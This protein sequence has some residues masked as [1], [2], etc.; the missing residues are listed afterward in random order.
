MPPPGAG[1]AIPF[2]RSVSPTAD[3]AVS[4]TGFSRSFGAPAFAT[5]RSPLT[6]DGSVAAAR[7]ASLPA[8][9]IEPSALSTSRPDAFAFWIAPR[10]SPACAAYSRSLIPCMAG[11]QK[12]MK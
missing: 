11:R 2:S 10:E 5:P 6:F 1:A 9:S 3:T 7:R 8:A 12:A 4:G